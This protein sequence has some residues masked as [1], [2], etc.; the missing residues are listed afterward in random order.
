MRY[1]NST[2]SDGETI[3]VGPIPQTKWQ[4]VTLWS[5]LLVPIFFIWLR[6]YS[7]EYAITSRRVV[8]KTGLISPETDEI[9]LRKIESVQLAQGF[10]G[11]VLGYGDVT[12]TG[13]G[14]Q[15]VTLMG[16]VDPMKAKRDIE[17]A[18]ERA[19]ATPPPPFVE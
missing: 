19:E 16:V 9:R 17:S 3:C 14:N 8:T 11:R 18:I 5:L 10:V 1:V 6:R 15:V 13:Q 4:Y 12:V 7:T 2:L